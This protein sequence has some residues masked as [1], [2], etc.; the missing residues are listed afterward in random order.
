MSDTNRPPTREERFA[1]VLHLGRQQGHLTYSQ[2]NAHLPDSPDDHLLDNL[3]MLLEEEAI[4]LVDDPP[5]Q[6]EADWL[7]C[8]DP[9]RRLEYL[10][11]HARGRQLR[12]LAVARC[13]R[14]GRLIQDARSRYAIEMAERLADGQLTESHRLLAQAGAE[15]ALRE[16]RE[17]DVLSTDKEFI[18]LSAPERAATLILNRDAALAARSGLDVPWCLS[19]QTL[20]ATRD[21]DELA[22][23]QDIFGNPFRPVTIKPAWLTATVVSLAQAIYEERAFDR[24]PIL[25]DALEDAGCTN[26]DILNHCRQ[27]GDH[28]RGC[29]PVDLLLGKK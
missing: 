12:L 7:A 15:A 16:L 2:V 24:L 26:A 21:Q 3:L 8:S 17:R 25:G 28:A 27:P 18:E 1:A 22:L 29:W 4:E 13:R 11:L 9:A 14:F 19:D 20:L 10:C 5:I 23:M 6:Q